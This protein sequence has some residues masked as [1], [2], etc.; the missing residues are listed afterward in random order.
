MEPRQRAILRKRFASLR[1]DMLDPKLGILDLLY[2]NGILETDDVERIEAEVTRGDRVRKLVEIIMVGDHKDSFHQFLRALD[3][4]QPHLSACLRATSVS[5]EDLCGDKLT[6]AYCDP[7]DSVGRRELAKETCVECNESMCKRCALCHRGMKLSKDHKLYLIGEAP[8]DTLQGAKEEREMTSCTDHVNEKC[9]LYCVECGQLICLMC[10]LSDHLDH[11]CVE[12]N[13]AA[14]ELR[15]SIAQRMSVL[16]ASPSAASS[17]KDND[18]KQ[19][20]VINKLEE[21]TKLAEIQVEKRVEELSLLLRD[22]AKSVCKKGTEIQSAQLKRTESLKNTTNG[23]QLDAFSEIIDSYSDI[24]LLL[25]KQDILSKLDKSEKHMSTLEEPSPELYLRC[26]PSA[27]FFLEKAFGTISLS[28]KLLREFKVPFSKQDECL[29]YL[30]AMATGDLALGTRGG[31][32]DSVLGRVI[33]CDKYGRKRRELTVRGLTGIGHFRD[34]TIVTSV[35]CKRTQ[36][37]QIH[38]VN[39]YARFSFPCVAPVAMATDGISLIV[40]LSMG[41]SSD[42]KCYDK[43]GSLLWSFVYKMRCQFSFAPFIAISNSGRVIISDPNDS[44]VRSYQNESG[45][46]LFVYN[47]REEYPQPERPYGVDGVCVDAD[48][49]VFVADMESNCIHRLSPSGASLG[50]FLTVKENLQTP[51][52]LS[53]TS[54]G[55]LVCGQRDGWVK[56]FKYNWT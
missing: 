37:I 41:T 15:M 20:D 7:C 21:S 25:N 16:K 36:E 54:N 38:P 48:G 27:S 8:P 5:A 47:R 40:V 14:S 29:V 30:D 55:G 42:V 53:T 17:A 1:E 34:G 23:P 19:T 46:P 13:K 32:S 22:V 24:Q 3:E 43:Q 45:E 10:K 49:F 9:K 2:Q 44:V 18:T 4:H 50:Q 31:G 12:I 6:I 26:S 35:W 33:V 56:I 11:S 52:A 28:P 51:V 39:G